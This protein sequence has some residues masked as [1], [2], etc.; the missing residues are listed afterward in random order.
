MTKYHPDE[1]IFATDEA[2]RSFAIYTSDGDTKRQELA[3][4]ALAMLDPLGGQKR[5]KHIS[6]EDRRV[7]TLDGETSAVWSTPEQALELAENLEVD[8]EGNFFIPVE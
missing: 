4:L 7:T 2:G 1:T 6:Y 5:F 3:N 8:E